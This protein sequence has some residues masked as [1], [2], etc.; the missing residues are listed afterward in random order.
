MS[1]VS[2]FSWVLQS[3]Q[4]KAKRIVMQDFLFY[5]LG[6]GGGGGGEV[7]KVHYSVYGNG[8]LVGSQAEM[9]AIPQYWFRLYEFFLPIADD[10]GSSHCTHNGRTNTDSSRH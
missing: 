7:N 1:I 4:E 9:R 8:E 2:N 5:F 6:R 10:F 3:F